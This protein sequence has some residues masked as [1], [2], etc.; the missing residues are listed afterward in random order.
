MDIQTLALKRSK[1][2]VGTHVHK[3]KLHGINT[4]HT[5]THTYHHSDNLHGI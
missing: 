2:H 3:H 1:L 4:Y 5:E